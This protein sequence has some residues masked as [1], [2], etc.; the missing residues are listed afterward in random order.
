MLGGGYR[1]SLLLPLVRKMKAPLST[2]RMEHEQ[3]PLG[4]LLET[5][6]LISAHDITVIIVSLLKI[7]VTGSYS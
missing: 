1:L 6:Q 3:S 5:R 7:S 2:L 4:C